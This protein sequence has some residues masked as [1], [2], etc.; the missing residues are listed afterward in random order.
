MP[1]MNRICDDLSP[2]LDIQEDDDQSQPTS[3]PSLLSQ[4]T[5]KKAPA[6]P[7]PTN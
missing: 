4:P 2:G 3:A 5:I 6:S 7:P 1:W